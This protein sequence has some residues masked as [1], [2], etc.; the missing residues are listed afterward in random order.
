[1]KLM[2]IRSVA[3]AHGSTKVAALRSTVRNFSTGRA[4][5]LCCI[6]IAWGLMLSSCAGVPLT[7][8]ADTPAPENIEPH[9]NV[10]VVVPEDL[11]PDPELARV[12]E[13]ELYIEAVLDNMD[14]EVKVGQLL[15]IGMP[16]DPN[17]RPLHHVDARL[18]R[19]VT[20]V[21]PGGFLVFANNLDSPHQI[22]TFIEELQ[23]LSAQPL[24]I[25]IDHEGG[26]VSRFSTGGRLG[27][28]V[29]PPAADI[30]ATGDPNYAYLVGG[31]LGREL[32]EVGITM[33]MA[34]VADVYTN[35]A[36]SVIGDRAFGSDPELVSLMTAEMVR[37]LQEEQVSAV[38]KHFP[39]HG[40]TVEDTHYEQA[41]VA[42]N[43]ERLDAVEFRPFRAGI[44][45]GA[46]AV[47]TAHIG[48]PELT[49][50][51]TPATFSYILVTE[52]LREQLGFEGVVIT[53][54]LTMGALR[55]NSEAEMV[56]SAIEAGVDIALLPSS[57]MYVAEA[58]VQAV[59]SG[60]IR[61]QR[62]D[63]SVRRVLRLKYDRGLYD[64][65]FAANRSVEHSGTSV[66]GSPEHLRLVEEILRAGR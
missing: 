47:M 1:M 37:G 18:R 66:L 21:Q 20:T 27:A 30:G 26:K 49:G 51:S 28:T 33:N 12:R 36:N 23:G 57:P 38:L 40:D 48:V 62:I 7:E 24:M 29:V 4:V 3:S 16:S 13:R 64:D 6:V 52:I 56:I 43:R 53:D 32:R 63:E 10:T 45:A 41:V 65:S 44:S 15:M 34:P 60:R 2:T 35:P 39:G 11:E 25:G 61:E 5:G 31:L 50:S 42:H 59:M 19:I 58:L 54:S 46:D 9:P 8:A 17:L 14:L 55:G 22:A